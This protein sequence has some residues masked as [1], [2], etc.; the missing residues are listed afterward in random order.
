MQKD[1]LRYMDRELV[2][3]TNNHF[4]LINPVCPSC[5]SRHVTKQGYRER[6]PIL[7]EFESKK[8]YLRRYQCKKCRRKFITTL[9]Q[10]IKPDYRYSTIFKDKVDGIMKTKYRPLRKIE[11]D[12]ITFLGISP[13]HQTISIWI[14]NSIKSDENMIEN[15][16]QSYSGYYCYDEQYIKINGKRMYCLTLID[17]LLNVPVCEEISNN[18]KYL[19]V[20]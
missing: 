6:N 16:L 13:C 17:L 15:D 3:H 19:T 18:K 14:R 7:G 9:N 8:I 10:I 20:Y 1:K 4:E 12:L 11:E 5:G 2:L